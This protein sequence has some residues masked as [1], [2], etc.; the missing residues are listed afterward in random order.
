[1]KDGYL[2]Y[3]FIT[4]T[5]ENS[6]LPHGAVEWI[7]SQRDSLARIFRA[8]VQAEALKKESEAALSRKSSGQLT[9]FG[10]ECFSLKTVQGL[11][12]EGDTLLSRNLWR[13]DIPGKMDA[14]QPLIS[15]PR[16]KGS[17]GFVLLPTLTV[18]GNWNRKG[19]SLKSGD[20]IA[21]TLKRL[22][23]LTRA[24][25]TGGPGRL[26][27]ICATDYKT[28]YSAEGYRRQTQKRSKPLRDTLAHTTGRRLTSAFAEW[29]MGWPLK[30]T[31][32]R[33]RIGSK[34]QETGRCRCKRRRPG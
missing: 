7:V 13:V 15:A 22:P 33:K 30:W 29:W 32:T 24:D 6:T 5:F 34:P 11:E 1:M 3:T 23:T 28:P 4:E 14:L 26:P 9:L 17:D 20:G 19:V 31:A 2:D 25:G 10:P 16:I 8:Q 27:T 21:T 18:C 12:Q